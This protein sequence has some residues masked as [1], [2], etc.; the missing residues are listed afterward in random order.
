M[1]KPTKEVYNFKP[2]ECEYTIPEG[3][4]AKIEG[5]KV[6]I[7]KVESE[8]ER[9]KKDIISFVEQAIDSGYGIISKE[10]KERW[11]AWLEKQGEQKPVD[12]VEP[13]FRDGDWVIDDDENVF[14]ITIDNN[15]YQLE[16]LEG[17]SCHCSHKII[18]RKF[19]LWTIQDAKD[20]DV[21]A[22]NDGSLTIFHYRLSGLDAGLYMS[23]VLL[24]DKIEFKQTCAINNVHPATKEQRDLLFQKIHEAGYEWDAE[25]KE[26]KK[27]EQKTDTDFLDFRTWK[28]IVDAVLTE[29]EGMGQYLDSLF[30]KEVAK[31]LQKRFGNMPNNKQNTYKNGVYQE[32]NGVRI[33]HDGHTF[34]V[35]KDWNKGEWPLLNKKGRENSKQNKERL[36]N[37]MDA[38]LDWDF[39]AA[40]KHIQHLGTDIPLK[41]EEYLMTAPVWL[42]MYKHRIELNKALNNI[43]AMEIDFDKTQWLA[44]RSYINRAWFFYGI[45]GSLENSRVAFAFQVGIIML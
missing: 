26:L 9:I 41:D 4:E 29:K 22:Y 42:A 7:K 34:L 28:Y 45:S 11:I 12:K 40:T 20:G 18:E 19:R 17:K 2:I 23:H 39:V 44:Q 37:E 3:H 15:R 6:I 35:P 16:T 24:T 38:L 13:K 31:E 8:D 21:L 25:K 33:W 14:R 30:T 1:K 27:I 36:M 10:R 32:A 43:G 5:N